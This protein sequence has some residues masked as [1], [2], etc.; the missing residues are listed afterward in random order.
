M[1]YNIPVKYILAISGGVDSRVLLD[2]ATHD[3]AW[4]A[5]NFPDAIYP[6]DF[7]VAHFDHGIRGAAS[8]R[9]ADFV[10]N[11]ARESGLKFYLGRGNLSADAAEETARTRRYAWLDT[12]A[13]DF[14]DAKI[15]TA[16]HQD[17]LIETIIMNI[18]RGTDWRGLSPM[19]SQI[20][21]PLTSFSKAQILQIARARNLTWRE[22]AT[23]ADSKYFRNRV[24]AW[25]AQNLD[26]TSRAKLLELN[27]KQNLLRR[28][29]KREVA[30]IFDKTRHPA[31]R[32]G[33]VAGSM[34][35][36]DVDSATSDK[37]DAQNDIGVMF[38]RYFLIMI[39]EYSAREILRAATD[40]ELTRPQLNQLILFVKVAR[41]R[42]KLLIGRY[43][44][45]ATRRELLIKLK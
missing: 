32:R 3:S 35:T 14:G 41:A 31:L 45:R 37:S 13:R 6:H 33:E 30:R 12:A 2:L 27:Q 15:V 21:R 9:D 28:E 43:E 25:A 17:D 4:R 26:A 20:I 19:N 18:L 24:R 40:G 39:D 22:D 5:K 34:P 29:I 23:N 38:L 7:A 10:A 16:H 8:T 42:K 1:Y 36:G 44:F 11:L